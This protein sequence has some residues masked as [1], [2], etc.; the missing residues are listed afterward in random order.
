MSRESVAMGLSELLT[1]NLFD[2]PDLPNKHSAWIGHVPFSF[3]L[4]DVMKP[5]ILVELGVHHGLSYLSFCQAMVR[6]GGGGR[7]FGIDHW[8]GDSHAG[9]YGAEVLAELR[10]FHDPRYASFSTLVE[11]TFDTALAAFE[12]GSVDLLHID[13]H[14]TYES[15]KKDFESWRPKLSSRAVVLL[16]DT[17]IRFG[18]FGVHSLW[19]E[20]KQ[21]YPHFEFHHSFGL[22]VLGYGS[23]VPTTIQKLLT[24]PNKDADLMKALFKRLGCDLERQWQMTVQRDQL[25]DSRSWKFAAPLRRCSRLYSRLTKHLRLRVE[26]LRR[27]DTDDPLVP[28]D[29]YR[30]VGGGDR[31]LVGQEFLGHFINLG[32]LKPTDRVLEVGAGSGRMARALTRYLEN[33]SYEGLEI[34]RKD[35]Q[36]TQTA[37]KPYKNFRFT[38]A[39]IKNKTYNRYGKLS[40]CDYRLPYVDASFDF[41]FLTSVF[42]H[43]LPAEVENYVS[44]ITRVLKPGGRCLITFFLLNQESLADMRLGLNGIDFR[45]PVDGK[46]GCLTHTRSNPEAAIAYPEAY[47]RG[48]FKD[49]GLELQ[50]SIHYGA[51][52][53]RVEWTSY[54]DIVVAKKS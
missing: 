42:T 28:P 27:P 19:S 29:N 12:D 26:S 44:E 23:D 16:H 18:D 9:E 37:Y 47:V 4:I 21:A 7:C 10:S 11:S 6:S 51:W 49:C 30:S 38:H 36:W 1:P 8:K 20:L 39:D 45:Y 48:L 31:D 25:L 13:G 50:G 40:A 52:C 33:G 43:M 17:Q 53:G 14:H 41:V 46:V 2:L 54:Q 5:R 32:Q 35:V 15:V 34:V 24:V 3:W 22:G